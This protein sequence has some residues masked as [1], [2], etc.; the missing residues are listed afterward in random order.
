MEQTIQ[1][2]RLFKAKAIATPL[3]PK[4][5]VNTIVIGI[6]LKAKKVSVIIKILVIA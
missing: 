2:N 5:W 4:Y 1:Y 3:N 6:I